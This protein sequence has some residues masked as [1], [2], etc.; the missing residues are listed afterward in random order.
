MI[1]NFDTI[2]IT[3]FSPFMNT[4]NTLFNN[5]KFGTKSF[6]K[7]AESKNYSAPFHHPTICSYC[8]IRPIAPSTSSSQSKMP[9]ITYLNVKRSFN[10][11]IKYIIYF[12]FFRL[13]IEFYTI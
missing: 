9:T 11:I 4:F 7:R 3:C 2:I 12:T 13:H 6:K 1:V 8:T 5:V 10:I